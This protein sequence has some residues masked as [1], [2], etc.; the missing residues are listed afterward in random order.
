MRGEDGQAIVVGALTML[1]VLASVLFVY[2]VGIAVDR[3]IELQDAADSAA[4]SGATI[5]AVCVNNVEWLSGCMVYVYN[6]MMTYAFDNMY[7]SGTTRTEQPVDIANY[8]EAYAQASEWIER[9]HR[10]L[11]RLAI[12]QEAIA[13]A[14]PRMIHNEVYDAALANGADY[15]AL[16]PDVP[17]YEYFLDRNDSLNCVFRPYGGGVYIASNTDYVLQVDRPGRG[18]RYFEFCI[19]D[20]LHAANGVNA[21]EA[22]AFHITGDSTRGQTHASGIRG[23]T[24]TFYAGPVFFLDDRWPVQDANGVD[25]FEVTLKR[26]GED[27]AVLY[28]LPPVYIS[29]GSGDVPFSVSVG[30]AGIR[31][32]ITYMLHWNDGRPQAD[33]DSVYVDIG[34]TEIVSRPGGYLQVTGRVSNS[35]GLSADYY[36]EQPA[37]GPLFLDIDGFNNSTGY[38]PAEG[39]AD[40]GGVKAR[41]LYKDGCYQYEKRRR[42]VDDYPYFVEDNYARFLNRGV[43]SPG[44]G[45]DRAFGRTRQGDD[46]STGVMED[47]TRYVVV[48]QR[49]TLGDR[50]PDYQAID[51]LR[52]PMPLIVTEDFLKYGVNVGC[53]GKPESGKLLFKTPEHGSFAVAC[54]RLGK[55]TSV[56]QTQ[57]EEGSD[58]DKDLRVLYVPSGRI[59]YSENKPYKYIRFFEDTYE[60]FA[61]VNTSGSQG[62]WRGTL[63]P[64]K[65]MMLQEDLFIQYATSSEMIFD[66]LIN[67]SLWRSDDDLDAVPNDEIPRLLRES[68]LHPKME[69]P[70]DHDD[71]EALDDVL[72]H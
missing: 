5:K 43:S 45:I 18:G 38:D 32:T 68:F 9:G 12:M 63:A 34:G 70:F 59:D 8:D 3:K 50:A 35:G 52:L 6:S 27:G 47:G 19:H 67:H 56:T 16:W 7:F 15:V 42:L 21:S 2:Q 10:W 41:L 26:G 66:R 13:N 65:E 72:Q 58:A 36:Y 14:A 22:R 20:P 25:Y 33:I 48:P 64:V 29:E 60:R 11:E 37:G 1:F 69:N 55:S 23:N 30:A 53:W 24:I 49:E 57:L 54:A 44:Y 71:E 31:A 39:F 61:A 40:L 28:Q 62:Y 46:Y 17:E 51:L 4:Y